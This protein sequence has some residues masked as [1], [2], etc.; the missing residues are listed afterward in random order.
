M[1]VLCVCVC[2]GGGGGGGE[3]GRSRFVKG[4]KT[5]GSQVITLF[6][7]EKKAEKRTVYNFVNFKKRIESWLENVLI[8]RTSDKHKQIC[9]KNNIF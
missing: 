9:F 7:I 1:N 5:K 4:R 8:R 3:G 6:M 2:V